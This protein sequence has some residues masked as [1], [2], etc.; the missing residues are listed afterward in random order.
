VVGDEPGDLRAV[1]GAALARADVVIATGG[2]GPTVDDLTREAVSELLGLPL[3]EDAQVLQVIEE[4]FRRYQFQMADN[5]RRQ[6]MVPRGA[7]VLPNP[8]GTAPGLL[9]RPAGRLLALLPGVPAEMERMVVESLLPRIGAEPERFS[10]RVLRIAGL[11]ESD[12]DRRLAPVHA[13]SAPVEWTILASPGQV[14]IH[15]R[16]RV[17][18]S[19]EAAGIERLD[20]EIAEVLGVHLFGR[21]TD[22]LESIVS[23]LLRER[24][25]RVAIAESITGGGVARRLTAVPGASHTLTGGA[26]CYTDA[27]KVTLA[28]VDQAT[29]DSQGAVSAAVGLQMAEGIR[30]RLGTEWGLATTGFAGPAGG[31]P[32]RPVGTVILALVGPGVS[33]TREARFPG[34]R[35]TIQDRAAQ[36]ALDLLRRGLLGRVA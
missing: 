15:L 8:L 25:E 11:G 4:R 6:A 18:G 20:R 30:R 33:A 9:L 27:A 3:A 10:R 35:G 23:A 32:D 26:V 21:D 12:V 13:G 28:G 1:L 36:A 24:G 31:E 22:T 19:E 2:L 5:N 34:Q 14:E 29:L 16:E 17:R 7:E